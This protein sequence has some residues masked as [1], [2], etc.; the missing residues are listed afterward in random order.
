[1]PAEVHPAILGAGQG[2]TSYH[3]QKQLSGLYCSYLQMVSCQFFHTSW[4]SSVYAHRIALFIIAYRVVW[5]HNLCM[6][7]PTC[8]S[9][10]KKY[11]Q[12]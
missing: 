1:M 11:F 6:Y 8:L 9:R 4:S 3:E 2:F 5:L 7:L 10:R 12:I